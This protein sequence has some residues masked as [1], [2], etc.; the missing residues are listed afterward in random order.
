MINPQADGP[1]PQKKTGSAGADSC[2]PVSLL[3]KVIILYL[4][5]RKIY[6]KRKNSGA[7]CI[8]KL[9]TYVCAAE[10]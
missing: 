10:L 1:F 8:G 7:N 9:V 4:S 6:F 5:P 3:F 2:Y